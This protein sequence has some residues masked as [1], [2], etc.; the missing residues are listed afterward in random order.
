MLRAEGLHVVVMQVQ[1]KKIKNSNTENDL[2]REVMFTEKVPT[3][4]ESSQD[5][6]GSNDCTDK[7]TKIKK[8]YY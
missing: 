5:S 6:S 3:S 8:Q 1:K 2:E 7:T 4:A